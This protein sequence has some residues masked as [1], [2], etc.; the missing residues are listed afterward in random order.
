MTV[1]LKCHSYHNVAYDPADTQMPGCVFGASS[2]GA[3]PRLSLIVH[4]CGCPIAPVARENVT[5]QLCLFELTCQAA[6]TG[7]LL[8]LEFWPKGDWRLAA[9]N[10]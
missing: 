2:V 10:W 6:H 1:I 8:E 7:R 3:I 9:G 4:R 5:Q